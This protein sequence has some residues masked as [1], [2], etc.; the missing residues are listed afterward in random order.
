MLSLLKIDF[1]KIIIWEEHVFRVFENMILRTVDQLEDL[2]EEIMG[3]GRNF[4]NKV[5][6]NFSFL[7]TILRVNKSRTMRWKRHVKSM[8]T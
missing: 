2:E 7:P 3:G 4:Y 8:E 5:L 6:H 1:L